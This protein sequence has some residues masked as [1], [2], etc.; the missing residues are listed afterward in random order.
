MLNA[1]GIP[2]LVVVEKL[3]DYCFKLEFIKGE[4]KRRVVEG[5]PWR[6]KGDALIVMHYDRLAHPSEVC[7]DSIGLWV[8]FLDLPPTMMKECFAKQL[9][10]QLGKYI[11][12]DSRYPGY[13]WV[14]VDYPTDDFDYDDQRERG[15]GD[16]V[17]V[18]ECATFNLQL[19]LHGTCDNKL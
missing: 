18:R 5:G 19:W 12:M 8:R 13:L 7:I 4:E 11:K 10:G 6:H 2:N 14:R 1:W 17:E 9:G 15:N 16:F 3:G